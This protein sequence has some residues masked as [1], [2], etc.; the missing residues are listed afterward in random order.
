MASLERGIRTPL[1]LI[2]ETD[3]LRLELGNRASDALTPAAQFDAALVQAFGSLIFDQA[4][5]RETSVLELGDRVTRGIVFEEYN[6][7]AAIAGR[8]EDAKKQIK[9]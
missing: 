9:V 5:G 3:P 1:R 4:K 6:P 8:A 2:D 7:R